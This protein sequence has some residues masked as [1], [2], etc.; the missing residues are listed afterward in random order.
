M[1]TTELTTRKK[2]LLEVLISLYRESESPVT[3]REIAEAIDRN[4]GTIRNQMP[5][6]RSLGLV[7]SITGPDGGYKP[8]SQT[9][10]VLQI[11]KREEIADVLF[12]HNGKRVET[13]TVEEIDFISIHDP[14]LCRAEIQMQ[15]SIHPYRNGDTITVGPTPIS[16]LVIEGKV[17]GKAIS[18]SSIIIDIQKMHAPGKEKQSPS[19]TP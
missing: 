10:E 9:Y 4:P 15:E 19:I 11:E 5:G 7:E 17:V 13:A 18:N 3:S 1:V 2:Q 6:L 8:T 14:E 12:E 16:G